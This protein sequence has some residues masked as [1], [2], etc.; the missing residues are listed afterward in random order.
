LSNNKKLTR[1][2]V[3]RHQRKI[4]EIKLDKLKKSPVNDSFFVTQFD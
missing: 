1:N 3:F 2:I 4:A